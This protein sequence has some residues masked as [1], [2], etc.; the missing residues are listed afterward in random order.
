LEYLEAVEEDELG[1]LESLVAVEES[2]L[3][4]VE[5]LEEDEMEELDDNK[6]R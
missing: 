5:P 1:D 6:W 2:A 4:E 3:V